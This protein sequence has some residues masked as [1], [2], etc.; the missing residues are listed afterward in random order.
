MKRSKSVSKRSGNRF[1]V[2]KPLRIFRRAMT[3]AGALAVMNAGR[4]I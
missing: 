4:R 3:F 1:A 2:R